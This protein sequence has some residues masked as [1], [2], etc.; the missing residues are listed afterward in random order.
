[1]RLKA[2]DPYFS[3][4]KNF[5]ILPQLSLISATIEEGSL[6]TMVKIALF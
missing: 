2:Y 4:T 5:F 6:W 3:K 1:V